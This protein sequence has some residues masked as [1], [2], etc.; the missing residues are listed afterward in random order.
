MLTIEKVRNLILI[1]LLIVAGFVAN[2]CAP[3]PT[4]ANTNAVPYTLLGTAIRVYD[5]DTFILPEC[6]K[7]I[8]K[9][10]FSEVVKVSHA[11]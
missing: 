1:L 5:G 10:P 7:K 2:S 11:K 9:D 3:I 8:V 6:M 4:Y